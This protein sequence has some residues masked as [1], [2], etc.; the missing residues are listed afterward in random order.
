MHSKRFKESGD[1]NTDFT[2]PKSL[3]QKILPF[4]GCSGSIGEKG[5][6][7]LMEIKPPRAPSSSTS[8]R[9]GM[10]PL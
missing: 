6:S 3:T 1:V 9:I 4:P 2:T 8:F 7:V 5:E 10:T